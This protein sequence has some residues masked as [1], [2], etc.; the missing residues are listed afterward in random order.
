MDLSIIEQLCSSTVRI[1]TTSYE[2]ISYSG[3][4]FFFNLSVDEKVVPLLV[5]N[6][7]VVEGMSQGRFI[8][9]ECDENDNPIYTEHV[10]QFPVVSATRSV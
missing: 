3:T 6:K 9:S 1:E 5:T 7:H 2:G 4:G 10:P 8:M